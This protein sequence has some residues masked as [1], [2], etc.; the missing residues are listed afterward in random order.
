MKPPTFG[1]DWVRVNSGGDDRGESAGE[2]TDRP[3]QRAGDVV[4][5][6]ERSQV[7]RCDGIGQR[8]LFD[9]QEEAD[10]A[11]RGIER[12]DNGDDEERPEG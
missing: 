7:L 8:R 11:G 12:A 5:R 9:R 4:T 2:R 10:V 6:E 1:S 3:G